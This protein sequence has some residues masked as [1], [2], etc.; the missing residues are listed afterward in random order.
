MINMD[1]ILFDKEEGGTTGQRILRHVDRYRMTTPHVIERLFCQ[2]ASGGDRRQQLEQ[3]RA[4]LDEL[5]ADGLLS[6][7]VKK[8]KKQAN[9]SQN[10]GF[11]ESVYLHPEHRINAITDLAR[12]WFCCLDSQRRYYVT[13]EEI[14]PLFAAEGIKPPYH[15][16]FHA[17]AAEEGGDVLYRLYVC[18]AEK[19]SA[20]QQIRNILNKY[21]KSFQHWIDEGSYGLAV[22][23]QSKQKAKEIEALLDESYAGKST[24]NDRARF[25]IRVAPAESDYAEA[26]VRYERQL[27]Q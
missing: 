11:E 17:I 8:G 6:R 1:S 16:F 13:H 18:K 21:A 20:G 25:L 27:W 15:N 23:V 10:N 26:I 22:I 5:V 19:K 2:E 12:L 24:L 4:M 14:K 7:L 9:S 3:A